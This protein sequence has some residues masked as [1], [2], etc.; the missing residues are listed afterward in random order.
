MSQA[1]ELVQFINGQ[2]ANAQ[3][4]NS[5]FQILDERLSE[6]EVLLNAEAS[7][8][9]MVGLTGGWYLDVIDCSQDP[10]ALG[11]EFSILRTNKFI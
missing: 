10:K 4:V 2:I 3:D 7:Y 11:N 9:S 5:N 8:S 6:I 1:E